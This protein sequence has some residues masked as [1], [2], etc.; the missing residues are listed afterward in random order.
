M[1]DPDFAELARKLHEKKN[2]DF[3]PFY[4]QL[5]MLEMMQCGVPGC[6]PGGTALQEMCQSMEKNFTFFK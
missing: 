3:P 1:G 5:N 4:K 2:T 6:C